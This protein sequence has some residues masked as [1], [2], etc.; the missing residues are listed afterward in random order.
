MRETSIQI[1]RTIVCSIFMFLVAVAAP[2]CCGAQS[3]L[4]PLAVSAEAVR[5]MARYSLR[6]YHNGNATN[7]VKGLLFTPKPVGGK[8]LPMVVYLPGNGE[9]GD[10]VRQFR[11]RA[12]FERVT[13]PRFQK[14]FPCH[15]LAV[16]PPEGAT[17][18]L[19]GLPGRPS[20]IQKDIYEFVM[21]ACRS[22][23]RP[24]VDMDRIYLTGFS[25]GGNG[26]YALALHYP[27]VFAASLSVAALPPQFEY[28]SSDKPGN[29]WHFHNEG[30]Y[31]RHGLD[32][33]GLERFR[34]AVNK[35][36]GDFRIGVYP[37]TG[38]DAWTKAWREDE[39]WR[40]MFSKS[41]AGGAVVNRWAGQPSVSFTGARCSASRPGRDASMGP[42]RAIDGLSTT[43]YVSD[44]P[45]G[46]EDWWR[47]DFP[48]PVSGRFKFVSGSVGGNEFFRG[49]VVEVSVDGKRWTHAASF[50][51]K[52]GVCA[53]TQMRP[54][55]CVR[56]RNAR[57]QPRSLVLRSLSV[58]PFAE[59]R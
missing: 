10:V 48:S 16:S 46:R 13:S 30:D 59:K 8:P 52:T 54:V 49:G 41:L 24:K 14:Q 29:W 35:A 53:F 2:H 37:A 18:L 5:Q 6:A 25:Y 36:G 50:G 42:M 33:R 4:R 3:V 31:G 1:A 22:Q 55:S 21:A 20:R 47:I 15:L 23:K 11:Q 45:F 26:V 56:V 7:S 40:W 34:D 28:F 44:K 43:C 38:H 58:V 9:R 27:G 19:G 17:T 12:I 57:T 32:A 51:T 39:A